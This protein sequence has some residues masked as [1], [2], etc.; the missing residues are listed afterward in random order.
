MRKERW[1]NPPRGEILIEE[2]RIV[3]LGAALSAEAEVNDP[4][5]LLVLQA[6][7]V[8]SQLD[9]DTGA[10]RTA[11]TFETR[12]RGAFILCQRPAWLSRFVFSEANLPSKRRSYGVVGRFRWGHYDPLRGAHPVTLIEKWWKAASSCRASSPWPRHGHV[13][14]T[15]VCNIVAT[16]KNAKISTWPG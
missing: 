2:G 11:G 3:A 4:A 15:N 13:V 7:D 5:G 6:A 1:D 14:E 12:T 16:V 8:H 10:A 9:C